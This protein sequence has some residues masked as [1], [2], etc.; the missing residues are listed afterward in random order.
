MSITLAQ[1]AKLTGVWRSTIMRAIKAGKLSATKDAHGVWQIESAEVTRVY[2]PASK[3]NGANSQS[4]SIVKPQAVALIE[5]QHR[6][7]LAEQRLTDLKV[8]LDDMK[9]QRDKWQAQAE[10]LA[11]AP[12]AAT[13]WWKR[14]SK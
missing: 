6:A 14:L 4:H 1:A 9:G 5:A 13:S 8:A 10:R 7:E 12:P 3:S 2:P 11:L